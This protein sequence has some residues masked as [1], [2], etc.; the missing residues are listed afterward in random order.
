AWLAAGR[1]LIFPA[2][3]GWA[4]QGWA[5]Q[6]WARQGWAR[7]GWARQGWARGWPGRWGRVCLRELFG[8]SIGPWSPPPFMEM[9]RAT[10]ARRGEVLALRWCDIRDGA[11]FIDGCWIQASLDVLTGV[12]WAVL[13]CS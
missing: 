2:G 9:S 1:R 12:V 4:R 11:A 6:G 13:G 3:Q 10:G 8:S 5:R 7:Q